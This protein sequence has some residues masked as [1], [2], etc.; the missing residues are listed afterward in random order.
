[1]LGPTTEIR[2]ARAVFLALEVLQRA[3][4]R[5]AQHDVGGARPGAEIDLVLARELRLAFRAVEDVF[6]RGAGH[7]GAGALDLP[8]GGGEHREIGRQIELGVLRRII[9]RQ[10]E[11]QI[12]DAVADAG[13][14]LLQVQERH[15][16]DLDLQVAMR[17]DIL[18]KPLMRIVLCAA[19]REPDRRSQRFG[20]R[21]RRCDRAQAKSDGDDG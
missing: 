16:E 11:P 3:Q 4:R 14:R 6:R 13:R 8:A 15:R 17:R 10:H 19:C 21:W 7:G 9:G 1:M 12:G 2:R 18:C 20:R 5:R